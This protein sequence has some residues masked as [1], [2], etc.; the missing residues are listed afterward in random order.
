MPKYDEEHIKSYSQMME[1]ARSISPDA[2]VRKHD[3][4]DSW[5]IY[6]PTEFTANH[7]LPEEYK[8]TP[9]WDA[10][11]NYDARYGSDLGCW[12]ENRGLEQYPI[13]AVAELYN[14]SHKQMIR[15]QELLSA[16]ENESGIYPK[17]YET[18]L[19]GQA[20]RWSDKNNE[21]KDQA[22]EELKDEW[23]ALNKKWDV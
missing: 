20:K 1:I 22:R 10:E 6:I 19:A 2:K 5:E 14:L 21:F 11:H 17:N 7:N 9:A 4:N 16:F 15:Q 18:L 8:D 12:A 3:F 23:A 13:E